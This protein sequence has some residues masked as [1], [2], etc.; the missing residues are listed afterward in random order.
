MRRL[1]SSVVLIGFVASGSLGQDRPEPLVRLEGQRAGLQT[2]QVEWSRWTHDKGD[3]FRFYTSR[4][5]GRSMAVD[6]RGDSAGHIGGEP[7][8]RRRG[9][10]DLRRTLIAGD[11]VWMYEQGNVTASVFP[12]ARGAF[13]D[14]CALGLSYSFSLRDVPDT[15][16]FDGP[17]ARPRTYDVSETD[18]RVVVRAQTDRGEVT[19]W[20]N[21]E[22][23]WNAERVTR[24]EDG[25]IVQ[26]SRSTLK[27]YGDIWYPETVLFFSST[28]HDG[29]EPCEIVRIHSASFNQ[30]DHPQQLT[31][32]DIGID[33]CFNVELHDE[34]R[35]PVG[36]FKWTGDEIVTV[37]EYNRRSKAGEVKP[38]PHFER[39][40]AV[41][42]ER[43]DR[44]REAGDPRLSAH[45]LRTAQMAL[46][47][48][49]MKT[50]YESVWE[51]Y[52]RQ[53][54]DRY[55]LDG[56]QSEKAWGV[57]RDCQQ[58]ANQYL[59]GRKAAFEKLQKSLEGVNQAKVEDRQR[60]MAEVEQRRQALIKP[61][62]DIFEKRLKPG[63]EK[64]P[65]RAQ[66][67]AAEQRDGATSRPTGTGKGG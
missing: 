10:G 40:A 54:I 39:L 8:S 2:A 43:A 3:D 57:L 41:L 17:Q 65:T 4:I 28:Y 48:D 61:L 11:Q 35:K 56:E 32:A 5:A 64:L 47:S 44:L 21:P 66:R 37:E 42:R 33:S 6:Q 13:Y 25:Q 15:L 49:A 29:R 50:G 9:D 53:F 34:N 19:W 23:G 38:G 67:K 59:D 55:T 22:R 58:R 51:A 18:G 20:L 60:A 26:E 16:W 52:T 46:A 12:R 62:D 45:D 63:L 1:V 27:Q 36:L 31:P 24:A 30:P 7:T 14:L